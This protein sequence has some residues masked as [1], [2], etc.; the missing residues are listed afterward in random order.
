MKAPSKNKYAAVV[1]QD[2]HEEGRH[3]PV[4]TAIGVEASSKTSSTVDIQVL[5][6]DQSWTKGEVQSP[7]YR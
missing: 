5:D 2:S 3:L 4:S 1:L 6:V 7:A